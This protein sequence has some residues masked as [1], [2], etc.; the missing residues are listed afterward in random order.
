MINFR[1]RWGLGCA[2]A[3]VIV[4]VVAGILWIG[5][6][7]RT[8]SDFRSG[9]DEQGTASDL[10]GKPVNPLTGT[11]DRAVVLVFLKTDCPI[12]NS[13]APEIRR[14]YDKYTA[15]GIAF[16][17]IYPDGDTPTQEIIRHQAEYQLPENTL[18]DPTHTLVSLSEVSATPAAAVFLKGGQLVYHGRIDNRYEALGKSRPQAT[19][20]DLREVLQRVL[21]GEA[22]TPYSTRAVGCSINSA[23]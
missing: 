18:V 2:L 3:F 17:M 4:G 5:E 9:A 15:L 7:R 13:Y 12:S 20:H 22:I 21:R 16:W 14:L 6:A 19:R 10:T 11:Q 8:K 1:L 23:S